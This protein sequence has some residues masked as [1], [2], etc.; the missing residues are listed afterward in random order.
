LRARRE[1][2]ERGAA[3]ATEA[4]VATSA[5]ANAIRIAG[6]GNYLTSPG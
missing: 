2:V 6:H 5:D 1:R 4:T 3:I